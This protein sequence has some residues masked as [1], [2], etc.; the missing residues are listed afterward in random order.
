MF[1]LFA[2]DVSHRHGACARE[3]RMR[4]VHVQANTVVNSVVLLIVVRMELA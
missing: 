2:S 3:K 4:W 1:S